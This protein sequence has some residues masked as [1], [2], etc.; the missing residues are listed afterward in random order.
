MRRK[1]LLP[2]RTFDAQD[3]DP[4]SLQND[5]LSDAL[6]MDAGTAAGAQLQLCTSTAG[7]SG[8]ELAVLHAAVR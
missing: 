1:T 5:A 4:T 8:C 6:G 3:L 2:S 7:N